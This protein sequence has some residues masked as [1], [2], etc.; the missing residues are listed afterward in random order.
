[1]NDTLSDKEYHPSARFAY[2]WLKG[3]DFAELAT[4]LESFTSVA[5]EGNRLAEI[6]AGTLQRFLR[7]EPVSDRYLLGLVY[8]MR[9]IEEKVVDKV[10]GETHC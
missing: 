1:M 7:G 5:I 6:C 4:W 3:R 10:G 2:Y 8:A 9:F